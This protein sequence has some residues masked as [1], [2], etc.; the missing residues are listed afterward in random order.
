MMKQ[1][2]SR[3]KEKRSGRSATHEMKIPREMGE[4][5]DAYLHTHRL[6][7]LSEHVE[8]VLPL[9]LRD[10]YELGVG[11]VSLDHEVDELTGR[12]LA[13]FVHPPAR[14]AGRDETRGQTRKISIGQRMV[15]SVHGILVGSPDTVDENS[16]GRLR[17]EGGRDA[18][19]KDVEARDVG[20]QLTWTM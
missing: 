2:S 12:R 15:G 16:L 1:V 11:G 7:S 17:K 8:H 18:L 10:L 5:L 14:E 13:S 6:E 9:L 4:R 3:P 19:Q 20:E